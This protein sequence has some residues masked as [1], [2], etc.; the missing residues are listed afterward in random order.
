MDSFA[1]SYFSGSGIYSSGSTFDLISYI[2]TRVGDSSIVAKKLKLWSP[3]NIAV[4]INSGGWSDL[5][6]DS[7][8]SV[9][10]NLALGEVYVSQLYI[11]APSASA[12]YIEMLY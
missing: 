7:S 3:T 11:S 10:L 8:G 1:G 12:L 4:K 9:A 2:R 6:K 5:V